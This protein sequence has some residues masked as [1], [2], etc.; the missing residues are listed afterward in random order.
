MNAELGSLDD[1]QIS[2]SVFA[3]LGRLTYAAIRLEDVTR[4]AVRWIDPKL[5]SLSVRRLIETAQKIVETWPQSE[6]RDFCDQWLE[7]SSNALLRRNEVIHSIP[8]IYVELIDAEGGMNEVGPVLEHNPR[9]QHQTP[10][11]TRLTV[12]DLAPVT[13]QLR[14]ARAGWWRVATKAHDQRNLIDPTGN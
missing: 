10:G 11:R 9:F 1:D 3:E 8:A 14:T 4:A 2:Q 5:D 13:A 7:G 12:E 6:D